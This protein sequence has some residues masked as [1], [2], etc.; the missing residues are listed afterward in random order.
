M[1]FSMVRASWLARLLTA[2]VLAAALSGCSTSETITTVVAPASEMGPKYAAYVVDAGSGRVLY[3]YAGG[4]PRYPASLTK[5]MTLYMLFEAIESGRLTLATPLPV[6]AY[7]A[8]QAPSKLGLKPGQAIAVDD[9]IRA[10]C[11]K[12]ANDVAV[13]VAEALAGSEPE[14]ARQMTVRARQI[15]LTSTTFRNASGLPD[16]AQVTTARDM[17]A[18]GL[19]LKRRFPQRF[20]YFGQT[21]F[22][23]SGKAIRGHNK[24]IGSVRGVNGIKT[25]YIRASGFNVVTSVDDAGRRLIVV[26]MGGKTA[27]ARNAHVRDLIGRYLPETRRVGS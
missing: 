9:A 3:D 19:A 22:A 18:L 12:S 21:S 8:S 11:V 14:F 17:A 10:L 15:G 4:A 20:A 7:A 2:F 6:S 5:M 27:D 25:G 23:Y 13:V 26:M 24:L 16:P 1:R